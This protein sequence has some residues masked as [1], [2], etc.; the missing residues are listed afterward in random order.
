MS[1]IDNDYKRLKRISL[2]AKEKE[3]VKLYCK[4]REVFKKDIL[5]ELKDIKEIVKIYEISNKICVPNEPDEENATYWDTEYWEMFC[6][7]ETD[8]LDFLKDK[9][10][11]SEYKFVI[12]KILEEK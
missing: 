12:K 9:K 3:L 1:D 2:F 5:N 10:D 7:L 8:I 11:D 4:K 6:D